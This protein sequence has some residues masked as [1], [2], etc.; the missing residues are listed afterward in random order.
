MQGN[1]IS[2]EYTITEYIY[3]IT[4]QNLTT[5]QECLSN[6]YQ[7]N[8]KPTYHYIKNLVIQSLIHN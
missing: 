4:R 3:N 5:I 2:S 8:L 6:A 7:K 1:V